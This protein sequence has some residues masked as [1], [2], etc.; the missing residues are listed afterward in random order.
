MAPLLFLVRRQAP[1]QTRVERVRPGLP[2]M[3]I[4]GAALSLLSAPPA[5][6]Q[7]RVR[8]TKLSNVAFGSLSNLG[9]DAVQA[10]SVCAFSQ[11][12]S[13]GYNVTATGSAPGNALALTSGA[14]LLA[15][16][17]QWNPLPGQS[18]GT[19]LNSGVALTGLTSTATQQ[20]CNS[21]PSTSASLI[22]ILRSTAL[23]NVR[24]GSYAG[25]L[26]LVLGPE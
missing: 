7:N 5:D 10:Q 2:L 19:Q 13:R 17:V 12:A 16:E 6:A 23:S 20:T 21:G 9:A 15:Y 25:T 3:A 4:L 24:A 11:T 18:S 22:V 8:I 14:N 26:T 1:T